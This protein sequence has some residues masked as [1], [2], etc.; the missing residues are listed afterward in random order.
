AY[1]IAPRILWELGAN[2]IRMGC[3]PD[4]FNINK[5]VGATAPQA[6]AQ[7]VLEHK[8]DIGLALDGDADRLIAVDEKGDVIDGDFMLAAL[9]K[10]LKNQNKLQGG[11]VVATVMSNMGLERYLTSLK[12]KLIRTQVGDHY[13][14][15]E[16]RQG[17]YNLGGEQSG[18]LIFRDFATT[19]D[20]IL[21][22]L[23]ILAYLRENNAKAS[24]LRQLY[25]PWAQK[26]HNIRLPAGTNAAKILEGAKLQKA[27]SAS[28]KA[29][30]KT[31]RVLIRKSGTEP[32][33]RIMVEAEKE[34][35]MQAH[36]KLL[37]EEVT[38]AAER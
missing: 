9:A 30:G 26:L 4:G 14:E 1:K 20:G 15:T 24:S 8:A 36:L 28:E 35:Q 23:Q 34:A 17:G 32:L 11:G 13:V 6:L 22:A 38:A 31:G 33:I 27:I 7:A 2:V 18:H 5:N 16:M 21:A 19:G 29:L 10:H 37:V 3:E 12:L 25:Q